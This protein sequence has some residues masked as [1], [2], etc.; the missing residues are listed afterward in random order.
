VHPLA[1]ALIIAAS[2]EV[3]GS[4]R[5]RLLGLE[6]EAPAL[7]DIKAIACYPASPEKSN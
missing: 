3:G 1:F 4:A 6:G 5:H 2:L 7:Q